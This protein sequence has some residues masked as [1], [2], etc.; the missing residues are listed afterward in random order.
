ML[1]VDS[2]FRRQG[3]G[4]QLIE[5]LKLTCV[6]PKLFTSTNQS[7]VSMQRLLA[8]AQFIP[9]GIIENLDEGDPELIYFC[10]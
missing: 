2:E 10:R 3:I 1:M 5:Q 6:T 7:N 4:S 9:S 8:N